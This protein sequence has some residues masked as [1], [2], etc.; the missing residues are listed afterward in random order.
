MVTENIIRIF[1]GSVILA[2]LAL[3]ADASPLFHSHHW[4]WLTAFV[5]ANL[6]QFGFS[7]FC[8]LE[9]V[10]KKLGVQTCE[11]ATEARLHAQH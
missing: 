9:F 10:L 3:G 8:P 1:A 4:L 6:F 5:G 7:G 2:S 11:Q